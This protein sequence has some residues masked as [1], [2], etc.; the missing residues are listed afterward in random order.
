MHNILDFKPFKEDRY[1]YSWQH[2]LLTTALSQNF[3]KVFDLLY[4]GT[5]P[6]EIALLAK[7]QRYAFGVL[8]HT[9]TTSEQNLL[10]HG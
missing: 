9:G 4:T 10:L 8:K 3:K 5:T 7:Q 2:H 1:W 6:S